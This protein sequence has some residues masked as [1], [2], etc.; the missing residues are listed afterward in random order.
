MDILI[1]IFFVY[2]ICI[3]SF[4]N[5]VIYRLPIGKSFVKG[6]SF[7]P[8]CKKQLKTIELIPILSWVIQGGKC[9]NCKEEISVIYPLMEFL[10]GILF[11]LAYVVYGFSIYTFIMIIF[12]SMLVVI[13]IIDFR[14]KFIY[15]NT[16]IATMVPILVLS[17]FSDINIGQQL[18]SAF[19]CFSVYFLIYKVAYRY[20]GREAFGFGDVLLI[21]IVGYV[22]ELKLIYLTIFLPAYVAIFAY[23]LG[24]CRN[25]LNKRGITVDWK[26]EIPFAPSIAI[27][28]FILTLFSSGAESFLKIIFG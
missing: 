8:K 2:G 11:A 28:G 25:K 1:T 4:F 10:I 26:I 3:G 6:R 27:S 5:V 18:L 20:Y 16:L 22:V 12:W 21:G 14:T 19:I 7:C 13:A 15:D 23:L 24:I 17:L 9:K